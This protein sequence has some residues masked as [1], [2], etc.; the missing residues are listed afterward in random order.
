MIVRKICSTLRQI[1]QPV[2]LDQLS[3]QI[4]FNNNTS[5]LIYFCNVFRLI[6]IRVDILKAFLFDKP[7][8]IQKMNLKLGLTVS[9]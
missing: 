6:N 7:K 1:L 2:P 5:C 3:K 4:L 8:I 9:D